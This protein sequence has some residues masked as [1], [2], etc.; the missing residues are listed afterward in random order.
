MA[1]DTKLI[2]ENGGSE[3]FHSRR[4]SSLIKSSDGPIRVASAYVTDR[5]FF[6]ECKTR[7]R[8]LL[9]SMNPMDV[10]SGATSIETLR[11]LIESGVEIRIVNHSPRFHAK[12]YVFGESS[13]VVTSA[14][15]TRSAF[16]SNVEV[17]VEIGADQTSELVEWF[18]S[19]WE[20]AKRLAISDLSEIHEQTKKLRKEYARLKKL[21]KQKL[22]IKKAPA[23]T[24]DSISAL[25]DNAERFFLINTNRR[26]DY[27]TET[28]GFGL[29]ETM[30]DR[31]L[32]T[33]WLD[34]NYPGHME[35]VEKG[36]AILAF[37]KGVGIIG[38]GVAKS[39]Y[40]VL[41]PQ[42]NDRIRS[43]NEFNGD[44]WRVPTRWLA[45][46]DEADAMPYSNAPNVTFLN[47]SSDKY[48]ELRQD[49]KGH[50]WD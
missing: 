46:K 4:L 10:A 22:S 43:T 40:E 34:F 15:L 21:A 42:S 24:T 5:E 17:G 18:N 27:Q 33:A 11:A 29:E 30:H 26:Y 20:S 8:R 3:R 13:A 28:G 45:W 35:E 19:L 6:F 1:F 39:G 14:N 49:V 31:G 9:T 38:I 23:R 32:A 44:E 41:G 7:E 37:A 48:A 16:E 25:M 47:V 2:L 12:V 50:S 36:D